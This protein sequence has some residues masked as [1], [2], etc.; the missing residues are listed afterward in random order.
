[1]RQK[2]MKIRKALRREVKSV[3]LDEKISGAKTK[4]FFSQ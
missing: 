2:A 1:M 4:R 3:R